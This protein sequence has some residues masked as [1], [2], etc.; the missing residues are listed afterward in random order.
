MKLLSKFRALFRKE[1]I[2][3]EM[4]AEMRV[5]VDLQT[6][7]NIAAGLAPEA[8]RHA[9][10]RQFG[11]VASIQEQCREQRGWLWLEQAGQDVAYSVRQL[12]RMPGF[13]ATIVVTL[14]LGIGACT[15]V[16]TA[17]NA[18]LLNPLAGRST[19][20]A[21]I[22][23]ETEPPRRPQMQLSPPTFSDVAA[24]AQSLEIVTAWASSTISSQSEP[25]GPSSA[26]DRR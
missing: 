19:E 25:P 16:F 2:D 26:L 11:N 22:I 15:V 12:L 17:V 24:Q 13:A 8:A 18:T 3:A 23:H 21:V 9:A 6:D 14:A 5:H 7:R 4:T 1:Q 20:R 10:L